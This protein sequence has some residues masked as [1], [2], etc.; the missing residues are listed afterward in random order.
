MDESSFSILTMFIPQK[1]S[2]K[3]AVRSCQWEL[4]DPPCVH[5]TW[6]L[7]M[8]QPILQQNKMLSDKW[9]RTI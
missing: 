8:N 9:S 7:Q 4:S 2:A 3:R 5:A 1:M 6:T